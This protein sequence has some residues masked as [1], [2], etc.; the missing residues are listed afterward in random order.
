[1]R[2]K[3]LTGRQVGKLQVISFTQ[4][5]NKWGRPLWKCRCTCGDE[6]LIPSSTLLRGAAAASCG[7]RECRPGFID[8]KRKS[9]T[10]NSWKAMVRRCTNPTANNYSKYGGKGIAVCDRW[11]DFKLFFADMGERPSAQFT[12]ER[13]DSTGNYCPE[14]CCWADKTTQTRNRSCSKRLTLG[15]VTLPV[16]EWAHSKSIPLNVIYSRMARGW[17]DEKILLTPIRK[18]QTHCKRG[19]EYNLQNT[20][21]IAS[22]GRGC[23]ACRIHNER[24]RSPI[25]RKQKRELAICLAALKVKGIT[26]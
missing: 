16:I 14:N 11:L 21:V 7:K 13:K 17:E 22:G 25:R 2:G 6:V 26:I 8:G 5:S 9:I 12:I 20:I 23:R 10:C 19:H 24:I 3:D 15:G 4:S 18:N 1:M